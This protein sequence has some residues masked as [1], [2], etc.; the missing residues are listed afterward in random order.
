MVVQVDA[1]LKALE[2]LLSQREPVDQLVTTTRGDAK[3]DGLDGGSAVSVG[4]QL[5]M[6]V[7]CLSSWARRLRR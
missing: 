7:R 4:D 3:A 1:M 5:T 2:A 6:V